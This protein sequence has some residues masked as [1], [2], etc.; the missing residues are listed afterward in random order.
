V[1]LGL[2]GLGVMAVLVRAAWPTLDGEER[3]HCRWLLLG[4]ALSLLPV[5]AT[6]P[7]NR[8]L[9]VPGLGA[10]VAVAL[11]LVSARRSRALGSRP[12]GLAVGAGV[13]AFAHLVV[14]PLLWPLMTLAFHQLRTQ[15]EPMIQTLERELDY[16]KLP[17]QRVVALPMPAPAV[18]MYMP[19]VLATRGMPQPRAW[20]PLSLSPEPHVF[21]R[22]GPDAF[23]LELTQGRFLTSEFE[24]VFRGPTHPLR[25]GDQV[26]LTGMTV[27]VLAA[28]EQGPTR[29]GFTFDRPLEDPS[30]VFLRWKDDALRPFIP[31]P[32]GERLPL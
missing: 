12:R 8:L 30:L 28:D 2:L 27:T 26:K 13:L 20:W 21:T 24:A 25:Q 11:V 7:A 17:Q 3:R 1:G 32:V 14:A 15:T 16:Q 6:F 10:S 22:T 9:L 31:P 18:G 19:M 23:E 29:L 5:A 4:A